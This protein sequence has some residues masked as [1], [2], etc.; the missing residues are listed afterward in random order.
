MHLGV[1]RA[2][3]VRAT[4][5]SC[6]PPPKKKQDLGARFGEAMLRDSDPQDSKKT[7]LSELDPNLA[8]FSRH[9]LAPYAVYDEIDIII[10]LV[11]SLITPARHKSQD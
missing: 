8:N 11:S 1:L 10:K 5:V 6:D 3:D 2:L 9:Y 7:P 4:F